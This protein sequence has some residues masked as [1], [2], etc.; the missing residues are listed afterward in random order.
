MCVS[1]GLYLAPCDCSCI[2][3]YP[4]YYVTVMCNQATLLHGFQ[5]IKLSRNLLTYMHMSHRALG[6]AVSSPQISKI[7]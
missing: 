5:K 2:V 4:V 7:I 3:W 1:F 6:E